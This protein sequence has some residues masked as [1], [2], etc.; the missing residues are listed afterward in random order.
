MHVFFRCVILI[1]T[2]LICLRVHYR[3]H[4][5]TVAKLTTQRTVHYI[6]AVIFSF[7]IAFNIQHMETLKL[8]SYFVMDGCLVRCATFRK[9]D[10]FRFQLRAKQALYWIY[11]NQ[12]QRLS[13][14]VNCATNVIEYPV[15]LVM[16]ATVSLQIVLFSNLQC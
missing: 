16:F 11:M 13:S 4:R 8:K 3:R 1:F 7:I 2:Y 12:N 14:T 10:K 15:N 5:S 9:V 6:Q